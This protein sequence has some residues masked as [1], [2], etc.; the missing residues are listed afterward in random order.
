[1][2]AVLCTILTIAYTF[3]TRMI[4]PSSPPTSNMAWS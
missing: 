1:V 4:R 2:P 3:R